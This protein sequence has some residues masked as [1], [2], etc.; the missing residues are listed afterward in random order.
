MKFV[1]SIILTLGLLGG[2]AACS[3]DEICDEACSEWESCTQ[4][5]GNYMNY[6]YD[7]C[8]EECK[9]EGDWTRSYVDCLAAQTTCPEM[10]N[11][12]D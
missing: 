5:E 2:A 4:V 7:E 9:D 10:A 11:Q 6:S 3:T 8:Y 12:C 1:L